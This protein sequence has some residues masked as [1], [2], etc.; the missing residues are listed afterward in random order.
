VGIADFIDAQGD[1]L[2]KKGMITL[3]VGEEFE[4]EFRMVFWKEC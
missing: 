2:H 3:K 1:I 4:R